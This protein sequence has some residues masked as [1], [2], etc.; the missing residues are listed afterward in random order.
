MLVVA[1]VLFILAV[2]VAAIG[3][4]ALAERLPRN[5][6]VGIRTAGTL[7]DEDAF[8]LG[9][10]VAAPA[11]LASALILA[12]GGFA[13]VA[14]EGAFAAVATLAAVVAAFVIAGYGASIGARVAVP[15]PPE[16]TGD[17]GHACASCSLKGACE[18]A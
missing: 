8:R 13:A 12:I 1:V 9:N 11:I 16:Q 14:F 5:R 3:V 6:W 2:V 17:C 10:R 7:R 15:A 4:A 18:T